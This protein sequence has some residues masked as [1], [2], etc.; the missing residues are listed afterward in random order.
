MTASS[1]AKAVADQVEEFVR[2]VGYVAPDDAQF[3]QEVELF[4]A[5]YLDSMGVVR[6]I[7][8]IESTFN[9]VLADET[10]LD[11]R[12]TTIAGI[13][14]LLSEQLAEFDRQR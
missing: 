9:V 2:T 1:L 5:G 10:L 13:G 7:V 11:V 14:E 8:F 4:D 12:F 6:L 3:S